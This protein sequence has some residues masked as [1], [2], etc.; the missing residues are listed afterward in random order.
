MVNFISDYLV[1]TFLYLGI[2]S[3]GVGVVL[4]NSHLLL[5]MTLSRHRWHL[6]FLKLIN[7]WTSSLSTHRDSAL[8]YSWSTWVLLRLHLI[9]LVHLNLRSL[10]RHHTWLHHRG[11][12]WLHILLHCH[13]LLL[14]WIYLALD[15]SHLTIIWTKHLHGHW[16]LPPQWLLL[17]HSH[18]SLLHSL[19]RHLL[20]L[21]HL[22]ITSLNVIKWIHLLL[23]RLV[24][25]FSLKLTLWFYNLIISVNNANLNIVIIQEAKYDLLNATRN[26]ISHAKNS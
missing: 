15:S 17:L 26:E 24:W 12:S 9:G 25:H 3:R 19:R 23:A 16:H 20:T 18:H 14:L 7:L 22:L 4:L 2:R 11:L 13:L 21:R 8:A 1:D 5:R 6:L 10:I